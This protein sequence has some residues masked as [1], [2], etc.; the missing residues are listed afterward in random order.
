[1]SVIRVLTHKQGM[2]CE[3]KV[4]PLRTYPQGPEKH[5]ART[6]TNNNSKHTHNLTGPGIIPGVLHKVAH[7]IITTSRGSIAYVLGPTSWPLT[8]SLFQSSCDGTFLPGQG[9]Q[10]Y[11]HGL[12]LDLTADAAEANSVL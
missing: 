10:T 9:P 2:F 4:S 3:L 8:S 6:F 5:Q 11:A 1:M 12:L 7:V